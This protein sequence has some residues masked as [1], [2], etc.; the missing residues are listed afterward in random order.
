MGYEF[1]PAVRDKTS[2]LIALAGASGSGK[3]YTAI[4]LA[5]GLAYPN[6]SPEEILATIAR[7]GKSRVAFIDTEGGRGKHYAAGP[8]QTPDFE[9]TFPYDYLEITAPYTPEK[10]QEAAEAA[11]A[12]GYW[13]VIIDSMSH[14]Y[15]SEGGLQE[16]ADEQ[17]A[18]RL[19]PGKTIEDTNGPDGWKCWVVKPVKSPG[20]WKEPKT[21]HKKMV[22]R[23]IQL[24]AHVI[25]CLRAE[26]KMLMRRE[27]KLDANGVQ[28]MWNGAPQF[29]TK[30]VPAED[31]PLLERWQ[32]ICE[33]RFMYEMTVSFL[34]LPSNPGV[35]HPI[36]NLQRKFRP[37]FPEGQHMGVA[38]GYALADWAAGRKAGGEAA[39]PPASTA[40]RAK[41]TPEQM[42]KAYKDGVNGCADLGALLEYQAEPKRAAW[43]E[44]LAASR[45]DL[46]DE[47]IANNSRKALELRQ[48]EHAA[49]A[50]AKPETPEIPE[51]NLLFPDEESADD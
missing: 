5:F 48:A 32:P 10:Y 34:L 44:K 19:K 3:T 30:V 6:M 9:D 20:N 46:W 22:N 7:E 38:N 35:G 21:R 13:A 40:G 4:L 39:D 36:K 41:M 11:D 26:E 43:L 45:T 29:E 16:M 31:R 15:E 12:A 1:R 50:G 23:M 24:R 33:K 51:S 17:E 25:F 47:I 49:E 37:M 14:E 18:G 42:A 8:G 2:V 27:P 28:K